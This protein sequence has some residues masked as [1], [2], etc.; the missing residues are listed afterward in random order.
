M[1]TMSWVLSNPGVYHTAGRT[2]RWFMLNTPFVV[3]NKWN[4]WYL[5]RELP[6]PPKQSFGEW[7][8]KNRK[9]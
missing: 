6:E 8:K 5:Q 3:K 2:G 9:Q 7:Y 1:K 4:A